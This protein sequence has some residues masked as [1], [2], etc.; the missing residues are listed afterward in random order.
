MDTELV[1]EEVGYSEEDF[2]ELCLFGKILSQRNLNKQGVSNIINLAWKTTDGFSISPWKDNTYLF[3]FKSI[4]D[5]EQVM[6][7]RALV[8]Y[9]LSIG[10]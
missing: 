10:S 1:L 9:E 5:K 7:K 6:A 2:S 8:C 4:H 3:Q